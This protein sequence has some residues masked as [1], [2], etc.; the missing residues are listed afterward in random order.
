MAILSLAQLALSSTPLLI[1]ASLGSPAGVGDRHLSF[2]LSKSELSPT[3]GL[4]PCRWAPSQWLLIPVTR[5][6]PCSDP[7]AVCV[8]RPTPAPTIT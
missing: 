3:T 8:S 4:P 1:Q 5:Q 2:K 7:S 6:N